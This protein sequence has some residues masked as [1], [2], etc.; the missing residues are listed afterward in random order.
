MKICES[1]AVM[2]RV[3]SCRKEKTMKNLMKNVSGAPLIILIF[4]V[5]GVVA[6]IASGGNFTV[7]Q[8]VIA[9]GGGTSGGGNFIVE[10]TVGQSA[11][12]T[13]SSGGNFSNRGGFWS[14][15]LAPTA[16]AVS[17]GGRILTA[18]GRGIRNVRVTLTSVTGATW[19]TLSSPFGYYRFS[20]LEAGQTY[21]ITVT[22]KRF[23][24]LEPSRV[25]FLSEGRADFDFV[26]LAYPVKSK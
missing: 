4:A 8:S 14:V 16:A 13:I 7:E 10:G 23:V 9:S 18:D 15:Q 24:F 2:Q 5:S 26:A 21:I 20:E 19:Q 11:A 3:S 25:I 1:L 22:S 6:Q 17:L 12:G